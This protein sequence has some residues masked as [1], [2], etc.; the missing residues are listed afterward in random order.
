MTPRSA[1]RWAALASCAVLVTSG[2]LVRRDQLT[3]TTRH[4]RHRRRRHDLPRPDLE[5]RYT[6]I[7]FTCDDR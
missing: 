2:M 5:H 4:C 3:T 7:Q 1:R 6:R